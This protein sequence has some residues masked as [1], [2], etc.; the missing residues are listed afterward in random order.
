MLIEGCLSEKWTRDSL[1]VITLTDF[2]L[3]KIGRRWRTR[4][5]YGASQTIYAIKLSRTD[6]HSLADLQPHLHNYKC[7][8]IDDAVYKYHQRLLQFKI[9]TEIKNQKERKRK[10]SQKKH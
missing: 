10:T 3:K 6:E 5:R 9:R 4:N 2:S 1:Y 8:I 7:I